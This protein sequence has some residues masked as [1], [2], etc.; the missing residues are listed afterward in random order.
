[1]NNNNNNNNNNIYKDNENFYKCTLH[2][3]PIKLNI[4]REF[5]NNEIISLDQILNIKNNIIQPNNN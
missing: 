3:K 4:K 5:N 2:I 1:M